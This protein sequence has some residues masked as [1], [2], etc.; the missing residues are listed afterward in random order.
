[1]NER[2]EHR[3][4]CQFLRRSLGATGLN[5]A[6]GHR[7]SSRIKASG[8]QIRRCPFARLDP[9]R[10]LKSRNRTL[11][12]LVFFTFFNKPHQHPAN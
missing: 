12:L 6:R 8:L 1:M 11:G 4:I 10:F 5:L 9:Q 2:H 7:L 3:L